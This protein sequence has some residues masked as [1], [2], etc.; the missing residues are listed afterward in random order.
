MIFNI[1]Y[2]VRNRVNYFVLGNCPVRVSSSVLSL[3]VRVKYYRN[4]FRYIYIYIYPL[5]V[6]NS[7][8]F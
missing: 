8:G 1:P 2:D 5:A 3:S 4:K 7:T 6:S